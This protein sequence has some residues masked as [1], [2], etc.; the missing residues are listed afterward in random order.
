MQSVLSQCLS[1]RRHMAHTLCSIVIFFFELSVSQ[2]LS[3]AICALRLR[4]GIYNWGPAP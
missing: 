4:I 2:P 3:D 1:M